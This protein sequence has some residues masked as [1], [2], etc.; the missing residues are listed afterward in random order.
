MAEKI[1]RAVM[2]D[3]TVEIRKTKAG[4]TK[5]A[6]YAAV[7]NSLSEDLGGYFEVIRPGAFDESLA[8]NPDVSARIQHDGGLTTI[9]RTTNGTLTL[10][11]D[12]R[13]L[14]Y[15]TTVPDTQA[16]HDI[17]ELVENNYIDKSS[18]AFIVKEGGD[19]WVVGDDDLVIR[20][21]TNLEL[22]DVAPVD[23]PAYMATSVEARS[24]TKAKAKEVREAH[25]KLKKNKKRI[26]TQTCGQL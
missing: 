20:E 14:W 19:N 15:E 7:Y 2:P 10:R 22:Y 3:S 12:D 4:K 5:L 6:G 1:Q 21:L 17:I 8:S 24:Q 13:G 18:F 23:G 26:I 25:K 11:S 16:G 9:G